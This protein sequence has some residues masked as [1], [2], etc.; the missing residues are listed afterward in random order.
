MADVPIDYLTWVV[1]AD[2]AHD[3]PPAKNTPWGIWCDKLRR[4]LDNDQI[5][6]R[7]NES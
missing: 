7:S 2:S 5:K 4:Y 1:D 3:Y 6:R